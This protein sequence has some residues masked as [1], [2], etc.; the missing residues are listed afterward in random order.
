M[1]KNAFFCEARD[2]TL[3]A[4]TDEIPARLGY[5]GAARQRLRD[6]GAR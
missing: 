2:D 4:Q 1:D 5:G 6:E 3:G